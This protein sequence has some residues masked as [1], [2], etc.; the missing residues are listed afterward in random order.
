[1]NKKVTQYITYGIAFILA[2]AFVIKFGGPGL[3][4]SYVEMG[5]GGS[6]KLPVFYTAPDQEVNNFSVDEAYIAGLAKYEI[7]G[8]A[9]S[10][11]KEF[12]LINEHIQKVYFKKKYA[13][14]KG[15]VVYLLYEKP[16][17]FTSLFPDIKK[18]GITDDYAFI[19]RM[20]SAKVTDIKNITSAFFVVIKS[21]FTPDLGD[22]ANL[23]IIKF[24]TADRKGFIAYNL[25]SRANYF[26]CD[27]FDNQNNYFKV[28]IKDKNANLD[29]DKV[30][31]ITSTV[32]KL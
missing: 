18:Q 13:P 17:F 10:I 30:L 32:K 20:M 3:L 24:A 31:M 22:Q 28:Y 14:F 16:G 12:T 15:P 26:N 1:M 11:P 8:M 4:R 21:L 25:S 27:V 5:L 7:G 23:K 2:L 29:L 19:S 9:I 6:H